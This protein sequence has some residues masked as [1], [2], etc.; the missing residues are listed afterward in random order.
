MD[1]GKLRNRIAWGVYTEEQDEAGGYIW[2]FKV[3]GWLWANVRYMTGSNLVES[4]VELNRQIITVVCRY[5]NRIPLEGVL[6]VD[7]KEFSIQS[8]AP[9]SR[10]DFMTITAE[11]TQ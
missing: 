6:I 9:T 10:R 1:T 8:I 3:K 5:T 2:E 4:N 7:N 11:V